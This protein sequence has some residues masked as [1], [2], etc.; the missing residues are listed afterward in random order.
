MRRAHVTFYPFQPPRIPKPVSETSSLLPT[1][2]EIEAA[3]LD[4]AISRARFTAE[5][6]IPLDE[7]G[8]MGL[9][10]GHAITALGARR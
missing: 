5:T 8:R 1:Q 4:N 9:R 7:D 2:A 6:G 3:K 10:L